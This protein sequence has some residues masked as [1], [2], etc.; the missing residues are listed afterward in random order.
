MSAVDL[1]EILRWV[2][3]GIICLGTFLFV[4][5]FAKGLSKGA[6]IARKIAEK[7]VEER[8]Q[9]TEG[10][11]GQLRED[12]S[13]YGVMYKFHNYHMSPGMYILFRVGVGLALSFLAY[14]AGIQN[15]LFLLGFP[16]GYYGIPQLFKIMNKEDNQKIFVDIYNTYANLSI[17]MQAGLYITKALEY[18]YHTAKNPR[19]KEAMAELVLNIA[20]K[21]LTMEESINIFNSRFCSDEIDKMCVMMKNLMRYGN[22]ESYTKDLLKEV[23]AIIAA[24]SLRSEDK[25]NS[26]ANMV[27]FA[28]F[29]I[30]IA[31][32]GFSIVTNVQTGGLF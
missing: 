8:L 4:Y 30:V 15:A 22:N 23:E 2:L 12:M 29:A 11:M 21:T 17:Q 25:L 1:I 16:I 9:K 19:F 28:F 5:N 13:K 3:L 27:A 6:D 24:D 32:T 14:I 26:K 10:R 31:I 20:D 7:E 18:S